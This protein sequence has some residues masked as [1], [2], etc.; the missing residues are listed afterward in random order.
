MHMTGLPVSQRLNRK[1]SRSCQPTANP[2][3]RGLT[4]A[5]FRTFLLAAPPRASSAGWLP[6]CEAMGELSR[7]D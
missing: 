2:G 1:R 4:V 7:S 5:K 3:R 6:C